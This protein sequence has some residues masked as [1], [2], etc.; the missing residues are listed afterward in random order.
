MLNLCIYVSKSDYYEN[1]ILTKH[2]NNEFE[3]ENF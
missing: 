2:V 3:L 1:A